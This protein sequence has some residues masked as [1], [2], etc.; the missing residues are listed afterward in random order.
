MS[1]TILVDETSFY[2]CDSSKKDRV[3][4]RCRVSLTSSDLTVSGLS[5]NI[6]ETNIKEQVFNIEDITGCLCMREDSNIQNEESS[7]V[8]LTVYLYTLSKTFSRSIYR[9]RET[10]LLRYQKSNNFQENSNEITKYQNK[11]MI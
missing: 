2:L 11:L 3:G 7:S 4:L 10:I 8:Y 5:S 1:E 9:K 6:N